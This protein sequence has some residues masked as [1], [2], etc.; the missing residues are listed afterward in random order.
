MPKYLGQ[1]VAIENDVRKAT[2]RLLTDAYHALQK[3]AMLEGLARDYQPKV[4]GGEQLPSE[5]VRVQATVAEMVIAT[6]DA[7]ANLFDATAARDFTNASG[8]A[9]ADVKVDGDVLIEKAPVPYL[10]WMQKQLDDLETFARKVPTHDPATDWTLED[11]RGVY[12]STPVETA[13]Q[14]QVPR[15]N[16]IVPATEKHPAQVQ[17]YNENVMVGTWTVVKKT[18]AIPVAEQA[19]LVQRIQKLKRA[20]QVAREEANR[21]QATEPAVGVRVMEYIFG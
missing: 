6:R 19:A 13:R 3:P 9:Y 15:A 1:A 7:L 10:L 5:G 16:V 8:S 20:V 12:K 4:D 17:A 14:V 11:P 18:G 2:A 21:I